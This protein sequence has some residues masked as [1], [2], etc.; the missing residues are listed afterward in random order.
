MADTLN[1]YKDNEFIKSAEYVDGKAKV[2]IDGLDANTNYASGTYQV[3]RE[4]ENG[5]SEK[6]DVPAFKTKPIAVTGVTVEPT[7]MTLAP[8]E[9]G[10]I[11]ATVTP[12]TA[13]NKKISIASSDESIA[14]VDQN[15]HI[16]GVVAGSADVTVTTEDGSKTATCAV[17]VEEEPAPEE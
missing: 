5:E 2:N 13:T 9:E 10:V 7:T 3:A 16:T 6:V 17:T 4:S 12:S 8:D 1:V 14:T 15:G 11:K